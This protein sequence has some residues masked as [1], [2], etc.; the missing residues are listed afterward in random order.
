MSWNKR[1]DVRVSAYDVTH[2]ILIR[3]LNYN[4]DAVMWPKFGNSSSS[5]RAVIPISIL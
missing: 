3:D 1:Y 5:I 2:K 4:A